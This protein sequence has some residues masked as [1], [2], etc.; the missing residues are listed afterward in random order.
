M[1]KQNITKT[2][3]L[4]ATLALMQIAAN[5]QKA[6]LVVQTGHTDSV[7]SV[8]FSP[9][10]KYIASGSYDNTVKVWDAAGGQIIKSLPQND[11]KTAGEIS[12]VVPAFYG[13]D[14]NDQP[15]SPDGRFQIKMGENSRL[16]L[17]DAKSGK[18]L[19]SL[20]A[21]DK[22][23][24]VVVDPEG[25]FDASAGAQKLMHFVVGLE[26][27]DLEQIKDRYYTPN[28]LQRIFKGENLDATRKVSVFTADELYPLAEYAPLKPNE[29]VLNVKLKNRGGGIGAI[30][31][32]V[33][34][35]EFLADARPKDYWA[36]LGYDWDAG[37]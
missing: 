1:K 26:P 3:L 28:L 31:V 30:Q 7:N 15:I 32:F 20:I 12:A 37:H 36:E 22:T 10:G 16:N 29:T 21:L 23:D 27:I 34:D 25:R 9:D 2:I 19:A 8:A 11:P 17:F 33:N 5:A 14:N 6:E 35:A 24:W 13:K 18:L 4:I